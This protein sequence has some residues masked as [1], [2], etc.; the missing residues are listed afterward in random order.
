MYNAT[1]AE[2]AEYCPWAQSYLGD[3]DARVATEAGYDMVN[4]KGK[5]I[6]ALL[7]EAEKRVAAGTL[8]APFATVLRDPC[9]EVPGGFAPR[10]GT[11]GQCDRLFALLEAAANEKKLDDETRANALFNIFHQRRD[12][13][14]LDVMRKYENSPVKAVAARAKEAIATLTTTYKLK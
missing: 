5:Y 10:A 6:D 8:K 11:P 2:K 12:K 14:T 3:G 1:D 9:F 4:C 13:K 7:D